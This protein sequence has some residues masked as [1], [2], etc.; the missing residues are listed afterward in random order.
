MLGFMVG[1]LTA[2]AGFLIGWFGTI[3][4]KVHKRAPHDHPRP[5][6]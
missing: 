1:W 5:F 3:W 4:W 6:A 2:S